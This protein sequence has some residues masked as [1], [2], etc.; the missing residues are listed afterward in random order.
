MSRETSDPVFATAADR[1][2]RLFELFEDLERRE[3]VRKKR[4]RPASHRPY[5]EIKKSMGKVVG[6]GADSIQWRRRDGST[7]K[8]RLTAEI[9]SHLRINDGLLMTLGQRRDD[10]RVLFVGAII[11]EAGETH[12]TP[13]GI[14]PPT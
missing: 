9:C 12:C 13:L 7:F 3:K 1:K 6:I 8:V 10:W 14:S 11:N 5:L 2:I 4:R